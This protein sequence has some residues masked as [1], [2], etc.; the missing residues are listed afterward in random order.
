MNWLGVR[1]LSVRAKKKRSREGL[2]DN[3]DGGQCG[4]ET[5][6]LRVKSG[7]SLE[8]QSTG[9]SNRNPEVTPGAATC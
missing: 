1:D 3:E 5:E 2:C 8:I 4:K 6:A 9:F 7:M